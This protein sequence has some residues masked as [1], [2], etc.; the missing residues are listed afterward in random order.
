MKFNA[1]LAFLAFVATTTAS[2]VRI[3]CGNGCYATQTQDC[4]VVCGPRSSD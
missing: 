3:P 1:A 4:N 2:G